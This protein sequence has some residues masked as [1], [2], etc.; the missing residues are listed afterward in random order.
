MVLR[1]AGSAVTGA[2]K[3]EATDES[4]ATQVVEREPAAEQAANPVPDPKPAPQSAPPAGKSM[5]ASVGRTAVVA[6]KSTGVM[7]FAGVKPGKL[8]SSMKLDDPPFEFGTFPRFSGN[9]GQIMTPDGKLTFG[10]TVII[11]LISFNDWTMVS[12]G[13][14]GA[15]STEYV[16]YSNDGVTI[17]NS[18]QTVADYLNEIKEDFPKASA[19][20]YTSIWGLVMEV[21]EKSNCEKLI[22]TIVEVSLAPMSRKSFTAYDT[23][24]QVDNAQRKRREEFS[25]VLTIT[26]QVETMRGN[27]FTRLIVGGTEDSLVE[28]LNAQLA[29]V[30]NE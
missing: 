23:Q 6:P 3:F 21:S 4:E 19:K 29:P 16:R 5:L 30:V 13:E 12:P 10:D 18:D 8:F 1:K 7:A 27:N 20:L 25:A 17:N 14:K 11:Q 15:E 24:R 22:G 28:E 9:Q 26:A 2:G